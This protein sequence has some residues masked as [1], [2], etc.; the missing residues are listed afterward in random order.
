MERVRKCPVCG[1][2]KMRRYPC[3]TCALFIAA[4]LADHR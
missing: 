2:V 1:H 3:G 4:G